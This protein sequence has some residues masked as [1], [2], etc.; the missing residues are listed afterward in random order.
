MTD[1]PMAS[2]PL[3]RHGGDLHFA[4]SIHGLPPGGWLDLSTGINPSPYPLPPIE[5]SAWTQ[6]PDSADL[7]ALLDVA[8]QAYGVPDESALIA[9]PGTEAA[10]AALPSVAPTGVVA[11]LTPTYGSHARAWRM[12]GRDLVEVESL[13]R[14]PPRGGIIVLCNPNNPDGRIVAPEAL[15]GIADAMDQNGGLLVV[16]E[17][18]AEVAPEASLTRH[19]VGKPVIVL[20][21]FGKFFGLAG[22]RLGFAAGPAPLVSRLAALFGDWPVSGP[23]LAIGRIALA[24]HAWQAETR[25]SLKRQSADLRRMLERHGLRPAGGTDLFTLIDDPRAAALHSALAERGI[26]TRAFAE[27]PNWLRL[28][29]PPGSAGRARLDQTLAEVLS[30]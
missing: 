7:A 24:D 14:M 3:P 2:S 17:A 26:W 19:L 23:A 4:A 28:G 18:F 6:L 30:P 13:D 10:I 20:R 16:D 5:P 27:R 1:A 11:I 12:A 29:L 22:L 8:R 25:A 15:A 9:V 21:S